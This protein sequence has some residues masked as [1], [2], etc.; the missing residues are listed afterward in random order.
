MMNRPPDLN[1]KVDNWLKGLGFSVGNPFASVEAEQERELL[2]R[3]FV[4]VPGIGEIEGAKSIVVFAPRGG[5]KTALRIMLADKTAPRDGSKTVFS[6]EFTDF[7]NLLRHHQQGTLDSNVGARAL[8]EAGAETLLLFVLNERYEDIPDTA[9]IDLSQFLRAYAPFLLTPQ[10]LLKQLNQL[11]PDI[12]LAKMKVTWKEFARLVE[13]GELSQLI[14]KVSSEANVQLLADLNDFAM[15]KTAVSPSPV[16]QMEAFYALCQELGFTAVFFLIDRVD[17]LPD[18]ADNP[19]IQADL[20]APFLG[21]LPLLEMKG[22]ALK[23]FLP[24]MARPGLES[25]GWL[26]LDRV[27]I[28]AA[29]LG[30]NRNRL[31]KLLNQRMG[32]FSQQQITD[33]AQICQG[34]VV[35][36]EIEQWVETAVSPRQLLLTMQKLCDAHVVRAGAN[37]L[38][39]MAD[40]EAIAG[41]LPESGVETAVSGLPEPQ[42]DEPIFAPDGTPLLRLDFK[43]HLAWL[44]KEP[45]K[46]TVTEFKVL[47]ALAEER[48]GRCNR[49]DL[50]EKV[51]GNITG[52]SNETIDRNVS[53]IR[54][55]LN[56]T[57]KKSW[58]YLIT[59]RGW[60]FQLKNF[61]LLR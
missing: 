49:D 41:N 39:T 45:I 32:V 43:R 14:Q 55:K 30:W 5:G 35:V 42:S 11:S 15:E 21:H 36:E 25:K 56:D 48:D 10:A 33:L 54:Q 2:P 37:G 61:I 1:E 44:G 59:V 17:E 31:L 6:V 19:E 16:R 46:F 7:D 26:R 50:A 51:W 60:G 12:S 22:V 53:R 38:L 29:R 9:K 40:W 18:T 23:F 13:D 20:L 27:R 8:L 47:E 24:E 58:T 3:F 57:G 34:K 28:K 4:D 52:V